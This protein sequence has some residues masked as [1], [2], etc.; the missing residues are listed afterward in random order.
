M[1]ANPFTM[2]VAIVFIACMAGVIKYWLEAQSKGGASRDQL[3]AI[4][5]RL[6]DLESRLSN[7]ETILTSKDYELDR[8]FEN[9]DR[10]DRS[11]SA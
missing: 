10:Q 8:E 2:I 11:Q 9:L 4:D 6:R 7:V 1:I 3:D 5:R